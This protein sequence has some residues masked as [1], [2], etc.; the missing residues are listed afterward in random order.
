MKKYFIYLCLT[1]ILWSCNQS[2]DKSSKTVSSQPTKSGDVTD[3]TKEDVGNGIQIA[4]KLDD[5]GRIIESGAL[6]NGNKNGAWTENY[7]SGDPKSITSYIDG[8]RTGILLE[9]DKSGRVSK[10]ANLLN[11]EFHG[12][13]REFSTYIPIRDS[14]FKNGKFD[15][16]HKEYNE[17]GKLFRD[18]M[19]VDGKENGLMNYYND[20]GV[21]TA[22]FTYKNGEKTEGGIVK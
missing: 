8:K 6:K 9:F 1:S 12:R 17:Q 11:D 14:N 2:S 20:A 3:F 16:L 18:I 15:G 19:F 7:I 5:Q 22:S 4:T 10:I 21:I 13:Y